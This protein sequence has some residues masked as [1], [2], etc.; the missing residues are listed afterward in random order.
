MQEFVDRQL[1]K[2]YVSVIAHCD[3]EGKVMPLVIEWENQKKYR[4]DRILEIRPAASQVG[5]G[6]ILYRVRIGSQERRL[7]YENYRWFIESYTP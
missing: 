2:R 1:Y 6:G 7:F 5:G 4:I 3:R